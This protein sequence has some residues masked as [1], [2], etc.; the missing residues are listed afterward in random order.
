M[1]PRYGQQDPQN[2]HKSVL[3]PILRAYRRGFP[4]SLLPCATSACCISSGACLYPFVSAPRQS[5]SLLSVSLSPFLS[6]LH[7]PIAYGPHYRLGDI[8]GRQGLRLTL[9]SRI[10]SPPAGSGY[11]PVGLHRR[12]VQACSTAYAR[13]TTRG[14]SPSILRAC[15]LNIR[16]RFP[17]PPPLPPPQPRPHPRPRPCPRP[18]PHHNTH[19]VSIMTISHCRICKGIP[20]VI[21]VCIS[22]VNY[23]TFITTT[24]ATAARTHNHTSP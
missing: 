10:A 16:S 6:S 19:A 20:R 17:S 21:I 7:P 22:A 12:L 3:P 2:T 4:V 13:C 14:L 9:L 24:S 23:A 5:F 11:P 18:L 8:V 1:S 15:G